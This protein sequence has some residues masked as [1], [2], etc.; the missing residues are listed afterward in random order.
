[1]LSS[2]IH[3]GIGSAGGCRSLDE[4]N[5]VLKSQRLMERKMVVICF[6]A[7]SIQWSSQALGAGEM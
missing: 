2:L 3:R 6:M 7:F 5:L 1:M 4:I